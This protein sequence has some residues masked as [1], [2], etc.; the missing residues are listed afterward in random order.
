LIGN[1]TIEASITNSIMSDNG[2][3]GFYLSTTGVGRAQ[4]S[5]S[6]AANN[7]VHGFFVNGDE[8]NIEYSIARGNSQAGMVNSGGATI[9]VSNSVS[10]NNQY[11]F[12][13]LA[14]SFESRGN[15]TVRGN[16]AGDT[17]GTITVISGT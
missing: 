13:N 8:L 11:G 15:N 9:R 12:A 1:S 17:A 5:H 3:H 14:G 4:I 6:M 7:G 10:T 16:S 2:N